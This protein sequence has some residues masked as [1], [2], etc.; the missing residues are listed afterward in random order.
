MLRVFLTAF[1]AAA[2]IASVFLVAQEQQSKISIA[3][4]ESLIR[5]QQYDQALE[6]TKSG[7]SKAHSDFRLWTLEGVIL[8]LKGS[9]PDALTAFNKALRLS[10][11]YAPALKGEA[12]LLFLTGDKRAIDRKS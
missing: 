2:L 11:D 5:S 1:I 4:I 6:A 9:N 12:Q 8:S 10:P 3:S 7:L